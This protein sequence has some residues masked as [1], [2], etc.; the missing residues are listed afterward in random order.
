ML[1]RNKKIIKYKQPSD[2][3]SIT[4]PLEL[5]RKIFS[6]IELYLLQKNLIYTKIYDKK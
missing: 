1:L 6:H 4:I 3:M 5:Q 2:K